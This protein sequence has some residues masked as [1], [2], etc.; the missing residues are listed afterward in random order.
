MAQANPIE[1]SKQGPAIIGRL[2]GEAKHAAKTL[3][4]DTICTERGTALL[5]ERIDKAYAVDKAGQ[6]DRDL[7]EL[8]DYSWHKSVSVEH[9]ISGFHTRVDKIAKLNFTDKVKGTYS[10]ANPTLCSTN[11]A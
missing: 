5:L 11:A 2:T 1:E 7:T 6:L 9:Y 8:L 3:D 4:I 10:F